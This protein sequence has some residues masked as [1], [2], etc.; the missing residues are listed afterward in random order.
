MNKSQSKAKRNNKSR[1]KSTKSKKRYE[2][3]DDIKSSNSPA[4]YDQ[5]PGLL[6][7]AGRV[8]FNIPLGVSIVPESNGH[9]VVDKFPASVAAI[10]EYLP[11]LNLAGKDRV[12]PLH[13]AARNIYAWVRHANAGRTNYES[14]DLMQYILSVTE[15]YSLMAHFIRG[16]GL[17]NTF[18]VLNRAYPKVIVENLGFDYD[19]LTKQMSDFRYLLN[20]SLLKLGS[21]VIPKGMTYIDRRL[22]L[23][24]NVFLDRAGSK[25][26]SYAFAPSI[27]YVY[28]PIQETTGG[29]LDA[30]PLRKDAQGNVRKLKLSD[31]QT[32]INEVIT[33]IVENE[34]MNIMS[35]DILKAYGNNIHQFGTIPD[36]Y[37]V[38]PIFDEGALIQIH[39]IERL[40][41][42]VQGDISIKQVGNVLK[43]DLWISEGS[44]NSIPHI[45]NSDNEVPTAE[46]V[47]LATRFKYTIVKEDE[48]FYIDS[49]GTEIVVDTDIVY[50]DGQSNVLPITDLNDFSNWMILPV[51]G[52][53]NKFPHYPII[54]DT[55]NPVE[56]YGFLGD[57]NNY[58]FISD[59]VLF[60]LH[61]TAT[62]S[63]F[64]V[65]Q[66]GRV[67]QVK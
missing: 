27:Y 29:G 1:G 46:E 43:Q 9:I 11:V 35:G 37:Y 57:L 55:V 53:F 60:K 24:S 41:G 13:V 21:L 56:F 65:P 31:I 28:N 19:D 47:M 38:M 4:W 45:I 40:Y 14:S 44:L 62:Y 6:E 22:W 20:N 48:E 50:G 10:F 34:D 3:K 58:T 5:V 8:S 18:N 67:Q 66:V 59:N 26:Q 52:H 32:I 23:N 2:T 49:C 63:M 33:P 17:L 25:A 42:G 30:V 39:G 64:L 7:S 15:A 51:I 36:N 61:E 16:Y 12:A 54:D